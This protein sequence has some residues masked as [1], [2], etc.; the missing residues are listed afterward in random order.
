MSERI[1]KALMQ[2]FAIIAKVDV[3]E[4]ETEQIESTEGRAIVKAFLESELNTSLVETY[5]EQFDEY[6]NSHHNSSKKK[7][8]KRKRTSVNSV[9]LGPSYLFP[10][11]QR[12]YPSTKVIVLVRILEFISVNDTISEQELDFAE[13]VAESFNIDKDNYSLIQQ[14]VENGSDEHVDNS[15]LMYVSPKNISF[16]ESKLFDLKISMMKFEF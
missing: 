10:N 2:L 3:A 12:T 4:S 6:L 5:L 14:F 15:K 13:T 16:K 1:L 11:Q 9:G 8:G 7:D